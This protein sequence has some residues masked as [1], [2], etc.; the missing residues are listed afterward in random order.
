MLATVRMEDI[1]SAKLFKFKMLKNFLDEGR[2]ECLASG[3]FENMIR[4]FHM[5]STT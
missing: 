5:Q 4:K 1:S 3:T 2:K